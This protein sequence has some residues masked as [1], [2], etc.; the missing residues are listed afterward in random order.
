MIT[1]SDEGRLREA[2]KCWDRCQ[3]LVRGFGGDIPVL[4]RSYLKYIIKACD[5]LKDGDHK[6]FMV[7]RKLARRRE[8][9]TWGLTSITEE[10]F[11]E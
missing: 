11:G 7:F 9:N 6:R 2:H 10:I 4:D 5:S 3:S 8:R 1:L